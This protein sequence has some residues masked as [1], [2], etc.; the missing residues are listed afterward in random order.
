MTRRTIIV[1]VVLMS[2]SLIGIIAVQ[3]L[4]I[5]N[6]LQV[7]AEQ[8]DRSVNDALAEVVQRLERNEDMVA[9]SRMNRQGF[10]FSYRFPDMDSLLNMQSRLS[11]SLQS[12]I[13]DF[14]KRSDNLRWLRKDMESNVEFFTRMDS[15]TTQYRINVN[16]PTITYLHKKEGTNRTGETDSGSRVVVISDTTA[17]GGL[18]ISSSGRLER[19]KDELQKMI[20]QMVIEVESYSVPLT[21]RLDRNYLEGRIRKALDDNGIDIPFEYAVVSGVGNDL[22]PVHSENFDTTNLATP[23]RAGLFPNDIIERPEFLLLTFPDV[24]GHLWRSILVLLLGS[25]VF[26]LIIVITFYV[27]IRV[28]LRQKKVSEI[29]S[30][31]I[32]NMT[33][34]FKTPIA[35]ISLA[36][37]SIDSPKILSFPDKV[38]YFTR[39]IRDENRRMNKQVETVLQMAMIDKKDFRLNIREID[40]HEIIRRAAGHLHLQLEKKNGRINLNLGAEDP[41]IENDEMHFYNIISNLLDNAI[42]YS[43]EPVVEV[44]TENTPGGIRIAVTDNGIGISREAQDR[45]FD[46]FYRVASGDVHNVKGFGLGL[47]YVKALVH[48]FGGSIAVNSEPGRGSRFE[49][50][51]P[52]KENKS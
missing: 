15:M 32:N 41:V 45:I 18:V 38:K 37:D 4:W 25:V 34:E 50:V 52:K 26:T 33:H 5:K 51:L 49:I 39:I 28:I 36:V 24:K 23:Y 20:D 8:F 46:R 29:K 35:T 14:S 47:S 6:A 44:V 42:K 43:D 19:K 22:L 9:L 16:T 17:S 27:T 2:V 1:V 30:D 31:F 10:S 7:R 48:T 11:D 13:R 3:A 21:K 40:T 12:R